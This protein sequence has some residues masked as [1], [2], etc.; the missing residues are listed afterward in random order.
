MIDVLWWVLTIL[1]FLAL[2]ANAASLRQGARL[3]FQVRRAERSALGGFL[4]RA[5][6]ILP[7]RGVDPGFEENL[8][9]ILSQEYPAYRVIVVYDDA[10]DPGLVGFRPIRTARPHVPVEEIRSDSAG[11]GG[12]VGALRTGLRALRPEDEVVVFADS[13]IRPARDWLRQLVQPLADITVGASTG[14]RWYTP[15]KGRFWSLVRAEWNAVSANVLFDP[16]LNYTWGGSTAIRAEHLPKLRLEQRWRDVL[17]DDLTATCAVRE[18]GL[19]IAFAPTALV[20]TV[21]ESNR[22]SCLEWCLRQ[23]TMASLYQPALRRYAAISFS[24]FDGSV[25][26]G[27]LSVVLAAFLGIA[28]LLPAALFLVTLPATIAKASL[29]RRAF[30]S[31]A[32]ETAAL[33]RAVGWRSGVAAL[34]V[35]WLMIVAL[36]R[37]RRPT[38]ISWRG[39]TYDVRDPGKVRLIATESPP[40]GSPGTSRDR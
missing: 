30:L 16:R 18:A 5:A 36:V 24:V 9:A 10:E 21:E 34:A 15:P 29:R 14:F 23:T 2:L 38:T 4:P 32:P 39:R 28:Y 11:L 40:G 31:A 7:L 12:K 33:W 26:L 20:P 6:I 37:T 1:S 19:Q 13:D 8:R 27:L 17:S 3:R 25:I 35:P 22:S